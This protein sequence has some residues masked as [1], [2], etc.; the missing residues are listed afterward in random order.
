MTLPFRGR[1]PESPA[2]ELALKGQYLLKSGKEDS[3]ERSVP[4]FEEAIRLDDAFA[5]AHVGLAEAHLRRAMGTGTAS[6]Y[7]DAESS[8]RR[9][10]ALS[11]SAEAEF[12]LALSRWFGAWDWEEAGAAFRRA[13]LE[14]PDVARAHHWYAYYL[15][16]LGRHE[17]A[18]SEIE[19]ARALD[20]LSPE[21]HSD[22]GWFYF[23][24]GRYDDA[25]EASLRT[26]ELEPTFLLAQDC[27]LESRLAKGE[28]VEALAE[29]RR[30]FE[31][32]QVGSDVKS[33]PDFWRLR[34]ERAAANPYVAA[35]AALRVG[36]PDDALAWLHRAAESRSLWMPVVDVDPRLDPI[37]STA[38]FRAIRASLGLGS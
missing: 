31:R 15:T 21:I 22:V 32:A 29:A 28:D 6:D 25:I 30:F 17:E 38:G 35:V 18:I 12:V 24:A 7:S 26:L 34:L 23:F 2:A 4:Y 10:L 9:A 11:P 1:A 13:L 33:L 37:R 8:A 3:L 5:P 36:R 27:L 19:R 14:R 20:P 16:G